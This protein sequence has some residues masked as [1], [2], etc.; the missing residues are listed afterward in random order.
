MRN[1]VIALPKGKRLL[2]QA[3]GVFKKAGYTSTA[4]EREIEGGDWKH[5]EFPCD[6]KAATF[7]LVRIADIPQYVDKNWADLGLSAFDCYREYELSHVTAKYNMRGDNFISDLLPDL[8]L[9]QNSRFCVAG[10]PEGLDFYNKCKENEEK[11]LTVATQH[12]KI[13]ARY[14]TSKHMC[15]DIVT[16]TGS[17]ELMPKHGGVDAIF[18]IVETGRALTENGLIIYEEAMPIQTKLLV[19]KAAYKYD[20]NVRILTEALKNAI[21]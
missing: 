16:V 6:D 1:I 17:T 18:D 19:S 8:K 2:K 13:T 15:V 21:E 14:F 11:I 4:L 3:Y 10:L 9:C 20:E 7:L 5:L 12:P